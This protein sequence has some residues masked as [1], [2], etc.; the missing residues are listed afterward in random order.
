MIEDKFMHIEKIKNDKDLVKKLGSIHRSLTALMKDNVS[1]EKFSYKEH[2]V[3]ITV[4]CKVV[5]QH[6]AENRMNKIKSLFDLSQNWDAFKTLY[7][8]DII[9][10]KIGVEFLEGKF[11]FNKDILDTIRSYPHRN[12]VLYYF[13]KGVDVC[14]NVNHEDYSKIKQQI[15]PSIKEESLVHLQQKISL[16]KAV[17]KIISEKSQK[18]LD[19][20]ASLTD[21]LNPS[22]KLCVD[23]GKEMQEILIRIKTGDFVAQQDQGKII[24]QL[25]IPGVK[26]EGHTNV[27][28]SSVLLKI[29][30]EN[31]KEY[32]IEVGSLDN[33]KSNI[34][35][36]LK[37]IRAKAF[38]EKS[39]KFYSKIN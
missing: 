37:K 19:Y 7:K 39:S 33:L 27:N 34:E 18:N 15:L 2:E 6:I 9:L 11:E 16:I 35:N 23:Y 3:N 12:E 5:N 26:K 13:Q 25:G 4:D 21:E 36:T 20:I 32:L 17:E 8:D 29:D 22:G 14:L 38:E 28:T 1:H 10:K 24:V 31:P 30:L